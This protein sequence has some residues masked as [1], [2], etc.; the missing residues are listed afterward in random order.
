MSGFEFDLEVGEMSLVISEAAK[1]PLPEKQKI[2]VN[3][4]AKEKRTS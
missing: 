3:D 4:Y 2:F 1:D